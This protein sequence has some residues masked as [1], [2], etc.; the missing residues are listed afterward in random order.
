MPPRP[1]LLKTLGNESRLRILLALAKYRSDDL[2]VYKIAKFSGLDRK[3]IKKHL[4]QLIEA[5]FI[6]TKTY[7]PVYLYSL[8]QE[9]PHVQRLVDLFNEARLL[10]QGPSPFHWY[11][12]RP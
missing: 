8:N 11:D 10:V 1:V 7:G 4:R 6:Q 12:F 2:S 5:N 3:I 9:S